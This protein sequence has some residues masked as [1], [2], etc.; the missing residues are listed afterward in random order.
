MGLT[1]RIA[2]ELKTSGAY[3]GMLQSA[4]LYSLSRLFQK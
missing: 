2:E 4:I 3:Q 1:Q